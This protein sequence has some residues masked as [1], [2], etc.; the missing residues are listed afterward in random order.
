MHI[1]QVV[2][3]WE[4]GGLEKHVI[5]LSNELSKQYQ[6]SV[7]AHPLMRERFASTIN[8]IDLN[9]SQSRWSVRL[10]WQLQHL[11]NE[12]QPDVIHAQANKAALLVK[13]IRPLLKKST[14]RFVATLH[15]QKGD[16]SMFAGYDR[17]IVV[18]PRLASLVKN[19]PTTTIYNGVRLPPSF[20]CG[21]QLLASEFGFDTNKPVFIAVGRLVLAKGFDILVAAA[22]KA[23]VQMLIVGDGDLKVELQAQITKSKAR[24]VLAGFRSNVSELMSIVDGLVISSRFEGG[25]YTLPEALLLNKPIISTEV[26]MVLEFMPTDLILPIEDIEAL[27]DKLSWAATHQAEWAQK[28]RA[29]FEKA[30]Q[31]LTLEAMMKQTVAVYQ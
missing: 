28:M 21:R 5:E 20:R 6:V 26:G 18:S 4:H 2:A 29:S 22:A 25:P 19:S 7:I 8:F 30:Q 1:C 24:V 23:E 17:V 10:H 12:L 11:L 9:F 14:S 13:R 27:A 31:L 16:S 15:N 3:S